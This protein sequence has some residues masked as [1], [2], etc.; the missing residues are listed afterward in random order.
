VKRAKVSEADLAACVVA[1]LEGCG[2]DVYQEVDVSTGVADIVALVGPGREVWIVETK[3]GWSLDLLE[4]CLDRRAHAHR[5]FAAVGRGAD[6][7]RLAA[8][9]GLGVMIV[10]PAVS[11]EWGRPVVVTMAPRVSSH[12]KHAAKTRAACKPGHKTHA[13]AGLP[14][15]G[16]RY[17]PFVQ[18]CEAL[19]AVVSAHP[20]ILL[21]DAIKLTSHHYRSHSSARASLATWIERGKVPGVDAVIDGGKTYLVPRK[22]AA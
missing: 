11:E 22:E 9:L 19:H 3:V 14:G 10:N 17:T 7:A 2:H 18:T 8:S 6:H 5:V 20:G 1:Y 15:G 21:A 4:Q 16:G 12:R 13:K